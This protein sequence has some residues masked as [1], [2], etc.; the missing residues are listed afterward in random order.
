MGD[1][2]DRKRSEEIRE[3]M[4]EIRKGERENEIRE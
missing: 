3:K 4:E 1:A 2:R